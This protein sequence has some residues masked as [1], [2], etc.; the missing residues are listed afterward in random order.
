MLITTVPSRGEVNI[1][2]WKRCRD[3]TLLTLGWG[4]MPR[5]KSFIRILVEDVCSCGGNWFNLDLQWFSKTSLPNLIISVVCRFPPKYLYVP[6]ILNL[7]FSLLKLMSIDS[8]KGENK[9][10]SQERSR[11]IITTILSLPLIHLHLYQ[12]EKRFSSLVLVLVLVLSV[13]NIS[14]VFLFI[15]GI[16]G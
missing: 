13:S 8:K 15:I 11:L 6:T 14:F 5:D 1:S 9:K 3:G 10:I 2:G 16:N 7:E 4:I 12:F